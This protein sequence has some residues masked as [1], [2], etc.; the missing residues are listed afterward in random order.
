MT[1]TAAQPGMTIKATVRP[2]TPPPAKPAAKPLGKNDHGKAPAAPAAAINVIDLYQT[3]LDALFVLVTATAPVTSGNGVTTLS[4]RKL[5]ER[6]LA[7]TADNGYVISEAGHALAAAVWPGQ[8][9][10]RPSK[11]TARKPA[12]KVKAA[13]AADITT[14]TAVEQS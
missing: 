11:A 5:A 8:D 6:G 7:E 9:I 4:L 13:P 2:A 14:D 10:A 1:T 3:G 12:R